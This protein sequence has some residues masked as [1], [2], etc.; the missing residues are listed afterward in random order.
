MSVIYRTVQGSTQS[1][2]V[3]DTHPMTGELLVETDGHRAWVHP[4]RTIPQEG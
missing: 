4:N 1:G 3:L 2:T